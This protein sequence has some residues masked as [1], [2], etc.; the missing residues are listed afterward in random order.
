[1]ERRLRDD[2]EEYWRAYKILNEVEKKAGPTPPGKRA[3]E[4]AITCLRRMNTDRFGHV[5][6]IHDADTRL[7]GWLIRNKN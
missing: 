4:H 5:K 7:S 3:A 6:E 1:V 2:Q